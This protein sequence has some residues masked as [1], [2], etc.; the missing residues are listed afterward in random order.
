MSICKEQKT[1]RTVVCKGWLVHAGHLKDSSLQHQTLSLS[2][3]LRVR[4]YP[5]KR[6]NTKTS[7]AF[8]SLPVTYESKRGK[9][10]GTV[11]TEA[12]DWDIQKST[13]HSNTDGTEQREQAPGLQES[14]LP[15]GPKDTSHEEQR[16]T[17]LLWGPRDTT[18][19]GRGEAGSLW[20]QG[21]LPGG[22]GGQCTPRSGLPSTGKQARLL[23]EKRPCPKIPSHCLFC[24]PFP[25]HSRGKAFTCTPPRRPPRGSPS[26]D[27]PEPSGTFFRASCSLCSTA[28]QEQ[29]RPRPPPPQLHTATGTDRP[30][31]PL[32]TSAYK[33]AALRSSGTK[34]SAQELLRRPGVSQQ[35]T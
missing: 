23:S 9:T 1:S 32:L 14:W 22:A 28:P 33:K 6:P 24:H 30:P 20:D 16:G 31:L 5:G 4:N 34:P 21:T 7:K 15:Q 26:Q 18:R 3:T 13:C 35:A 12:A 19:K 17:Q 29:G 10:S 27:L 11:N 2:D 8:S 25:C